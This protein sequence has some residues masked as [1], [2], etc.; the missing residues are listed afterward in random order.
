MENQIEIYQSQ[1][2]Q[3]QIEVKFG[4]ETVWLD[5]HSLA[6]IFSVQRP[7]VVKH[8]NNIYKSSELDPAA[9]CSKMEQVAA[10][11]KKRRMHLYN[12]DVIIS[13]G[14]RVNSTKATQF[15]QWATQRL[16]DYLIQGY[17]INE[18][19][20]SQKQ[21]EV[22]TLRDGIRILSRAIETKMGHADLTL[23][24]HFAKGLELLDD[25][26]HEKLDSKGITTRQAKFPDLSDYRN[27]I[28]SMRRDFDSDIFGKEKDDSFQSSVA[29][30]SKGFGDIDFY[31][32]IEEKA[33]TLLYLII[34]NHSFIDG[35]KR[36]AAA[37][38]LLFLENND[39]LKSGTGVALISNEALAS[40]TLFAAASKP[41]EMET[42]KKLIISVLNRNH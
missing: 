21:Q 22:Q 10:D 32:S 7:A 12:L 34:K 30:I 3:T 6:E 31:P 35:N 14:Y 41:E 9:T 42:V 26:D 11:G 27:I 18:K 5:A 20:L 15:R 17:A 8:I 1:D 24:D 4:E 13:V 38:F 28:E 33:A 2:G 19:R 16:K 40:L 23:L 25:Y 36:I 39:L 29:Q 37:C